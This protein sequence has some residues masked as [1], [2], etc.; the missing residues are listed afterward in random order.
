MCLKA[1]CR[2]AGLFSSLVVASL[3]RLGGSPYEFGRSSKLAA[4]F[5]CVDF[6]SG[7]FLVTHP[8]IET[9]SG[10][11]GLQH[12]SFESG[13]ALCFVEG[14]AHN[15]FAV[16]VTLMLRNGSERVDAHRLTADN[17]GN[18]RDMTAGNI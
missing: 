13:G 4:T 1:Q 14:K 12:S 3:R 2:Q 15:R 8:L 5:P 16:S 11:R 17:C 9:H 6:E 18:D 10:L 7:D